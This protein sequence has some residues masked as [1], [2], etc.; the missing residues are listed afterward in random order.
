MTTK[1][2]QPRVILTDNGARFRDTYE[3]HLLDD[4][5]ANP[6]DYADTVASA[7]ASNLAERM[8]F[9]LAAGRAMLSNAAKRAARELGVKPTQGAIRAYLTARTDADVANDPRA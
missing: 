6:A 1:L 9:S 8:T 3:R 5:A 7:K 4:I 2:P